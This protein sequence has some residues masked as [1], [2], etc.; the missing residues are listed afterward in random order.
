MAYLHQQIKIYV[1]VSGITV[2]ISKMGSGELMARR[3]VSAG[4]AIDFAQI[5]DGLLEVGEGG[6]LE[7]DLRQALASLRVDLEKKLEKDIQET[8]RQG[9]M[10]IALGKI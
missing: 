3:V 5:V 7:R 1:D 8:A 2:S 4:E 9:Q 6:P 10:I